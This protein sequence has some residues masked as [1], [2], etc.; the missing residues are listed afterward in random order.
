MVDIVLQGARV[1]Y[2]INR[3]KCDESLPLLVFQ[4]DV[5][6]ATF[7]EYLKEDK[8]STSNIGIR[9]TPSDVYYN[10]TKHC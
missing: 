7:L 1:L 9:N 5:V 6:Y 10:D 4:R 3:D 2:C 8:L